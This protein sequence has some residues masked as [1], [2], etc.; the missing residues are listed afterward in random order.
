MKVAIT[1]VFCEI[2]T[3]LA[4]FCVA[5]PL[6]DW[7]SLVSFAEFTSATKSHWNAPTLTAACAALYLVGLLFDAVGLMADGLLE[8]AFGVDP[9]DATQR[10]A[11][12]N[13][14]SSHV[15]EYRNETWAYY[16]CYRNL[17]VLT[18]PAAVTWAGAL[19]SHGQ[20]VAA[21]VAIVLAAA[22]GVAFWASAKT[23]LGLYY[24]I[25]KAITHPPVSNDRT[26]TL[27]GA[28]AAAG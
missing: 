16:F 10:A 14:V 26:R 23:L 20:R 18:A 13:H 24:E 19:F 11:F 2:I 9:P 6:F 8:K 17:L 21:A 15:L 28:S 22:A 1:E 5:I 3:G 12:W 27:G 4:V 25:T 7:V